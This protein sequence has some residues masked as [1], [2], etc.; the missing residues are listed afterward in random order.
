[1]AWRCL[2]ER[3]GDM[4]IRTD[5]ARILR[6][7]A[8]DLTAGRAKVL[9]Q[10]GGAFLFDLRP[11]TD[12]PLL[13]KVAPVETARVAGERRVMRGGAGTATIAGRRVPVIVMNLDPQ[14]MASPEA[15][16]HGLAG[17]PP[18]GGLPYFTHEYAHVVNA[19][20][21]A[22]GS[23]KAR[24]MAQYVNSPTELDS[25]YH[26][27]AQ[28]FATVVEQIRA[29]VPDMVASYLGGSPAA[30]VQGFV[31]FWTQRFGTWGD[32][33]PVNQAR[34]RKR[35]AGLYSELVAGN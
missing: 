26:E 15:M 3:E 22:P 12:T 1:M 10:R 16:A 29:S 11:Y 27:A 32:L 24:D 21:G 6:A 33:T 7:F 30:F 17:P 25:F 19:A 14:H 18:F 2:L 28:H 4:P 31:A 13:L 35:A 8:A 9:E 34:I 5:A 20:R 23:S